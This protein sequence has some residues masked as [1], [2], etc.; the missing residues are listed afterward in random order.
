[1]KGGIQAQLDAFKAGFCKVFPMSQLAMFTPE[2]VQLLLNGEQMVS[3]THAD[4]LAYTEPK[5][6]YSKDSPHFLMFLDVLLELD[7]K[8]K[9]A[10]LA[11]AT[12]CPTLPPGG[13]ANLHPRLTIVRKGEDGNPDGSFPSVNTCLHYVKMPEYSS[14]AVMKQQLLVATLSHGFDLN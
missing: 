1:V 14:A 9:R 3:W 5:Y 10:F 7:D 8:E 6:G 11:F 2:E 13:L 12:G 4:L